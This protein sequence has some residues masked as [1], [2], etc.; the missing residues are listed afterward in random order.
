MTNLGV[1]LWTVARDYYLSFEPPGDELEAA[2]V[3]GAEFAE[4]GPKERKE[5]EKE[6]FMEAF[7]KLLELECGRV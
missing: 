3:L 2:E 7:T 6:M 1:R 5:M 4:H